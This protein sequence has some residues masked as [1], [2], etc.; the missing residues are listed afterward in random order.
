[1]I[2]DVAKTDHKLFVGKIASCLK[3]D[4]TLDAAQLPDHHNC[5][6]GKWYDSEGKARCGTLSSFR[7][8]EE[9]HAR[10]HAAAKNVVSAI[11]SGNRQ[12]AEELFRE[13]DGI[14]AEIGSLLDA[15]KGECKH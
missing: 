4:V 12:K 1:M 11:N 7:A 13:V 3:G 10:I 2:L 6:F 5:R 8:V 15:I 9:P 14:S